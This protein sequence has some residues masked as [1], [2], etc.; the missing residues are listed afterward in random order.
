M[1]APMGMAIMRAL[2]KLELPGV[3]P[4]ARR[5]TKAMPR[6][7]TTAAV[8]DMIVDTRAVQDMNTRMS[9]SELSPVNLSSL[10][11]RRTGHCVFMSN[12]GSE[13]IA[14]MNH[15]V[16]PPN[17][18]KADFISAAPVRTAMIRAKIPDTPNGSVPH[19]QN[20][21]ANSSE[22]MPMMPW[23]EIASDPGMHMATI[24]I[25]APRT[26]PTPRLLRK[27]SLLKNLTDCSFAVAIASCTIVS[28]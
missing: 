11:I 12:A 21:T 26:K 2:P 24:R 28:S 1:T 3:A 6:N 27:P 15:T 5:M 7:K 17:A 10:L 4:T 19:T 22:A 25:A 14:T 18:P 13:K 9:F 16:E 23:R 8:S 20:T